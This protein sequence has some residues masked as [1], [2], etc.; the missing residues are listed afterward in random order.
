[1]KKSFITSG[2][3]FSR[4]MALLKYTLSLIDQLQ[5][6][7]FSFYHYMGSDARKPDFVACELQRRRTACAS[8]LS[9]QRLCNCFLQSMI[10]KLV[11]Y[12]ISSF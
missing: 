8:V 12:I 7:H 4:D 10:F 1:M 9:D 3:R 5:L 11:S 6:I 2:L